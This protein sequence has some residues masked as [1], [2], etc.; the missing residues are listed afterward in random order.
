MAPRTHHR[1]AGEDLR[2]PNANSQLPSIEG[3]APPGLV[4]E[5]GLRPPFYIWEFVRWEFVR[6]ELGLGSWEFGVVVS[7][8]PNLGS[9]GSHVIHRVDHPDDDVAACFPLGQ[10][11]L[12]FL[13]A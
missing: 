12:E 10:S 7:L 6:W 4:N 3:P 8:P 5:G 11:D 2:T 9:G 13:A 1:Q